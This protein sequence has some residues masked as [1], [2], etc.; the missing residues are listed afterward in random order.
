M[1]E[2]ANRG[3]AL[4][5]RLFNFYTLRTRNEPQYYQ[6]YGNAYPKPLQHQQ[7]PALLDPE[8]MALDATRRFQFR[9]RIEE[10]KQQKNNECYNCGK[11]GY[12]AAQCPTKRPNQY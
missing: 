9:N 4:D 1:I 7:E 8:P 12:Y 2:F 3:I 5:N 6:E 10:E 11:M